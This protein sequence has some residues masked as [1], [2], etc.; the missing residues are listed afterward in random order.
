MAEAGE[1]IS[2]VVSFYQISYIL[3]LQQHDRLVAGAHEE[4]DREGEECQPEQGVL[5]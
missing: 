3:E 5:N 4:L 2:V 1:N